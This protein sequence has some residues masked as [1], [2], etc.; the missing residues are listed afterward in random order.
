MTEPG[1]GKRGETRTT[2]APVAGLQPEWMLTPVDRDSPAVTFGDVSMSWRDVELRGRR[3]ARALDGAG[4]ATGAVWGVLAHNGLEW[5][6]LT[7]GNVCAGARIVPLN[8]HLTATEVAALL[9]DSGC[10]LIITDASL[11]D[12]ATEAASIAGV[13]RVIELGP[14]Y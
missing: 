7:L 4:V 1:S 9:A 12:L 14:E 8:W 3:V 6:E 13:D 10:R 5:V 2:A 11:S